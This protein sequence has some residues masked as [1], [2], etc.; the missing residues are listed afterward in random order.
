MQPDCRFNGVRVRIRRVKCR[1]CKAE[2]DVGAI[3]DGAARRE[4]ARLVRNQMPAHAMAVLQRELGLD[5]GTAKALVLH[6]T[7]SPGHCH[8]CDA[9]LDSHACGRVNLDW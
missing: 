6:V 2:I 1:G 4:A 9:P 7:K 5:L 8:H 3:P